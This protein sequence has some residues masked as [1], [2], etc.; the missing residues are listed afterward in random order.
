MQKENLIAA[1]ELCLQ[2][3]IELKFIYL[4]QEYGLVEVTTIEEDVF[5]AAHQLRDVEKIIR[6]HYELN[7][8][9]EGIDVI[10]HLLKKL[11][12]AQDEINDLRNQL[13]FYKAIQ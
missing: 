10:H 9:L 12:A 11:E 3:N 2:H 5:I 8:N 13:M 1:N 7:I 6:L 4:L